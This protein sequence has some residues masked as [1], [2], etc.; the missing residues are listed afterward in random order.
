N[1]NLFLDRRAFLN[2]YDY[3]KDLNGKYLAAILDAVTP[4]CGGINLEY[5]FS[6]VDNHRLGAGT[7]LPHN[8]ISLIGVANGLEGD[9]RT[10]L[11][12]QMLDIHESLRLLI[13][14][15]HFPEVVLQVIQRKDATYEW[16]KNYWVH[17]VV[18]HPETR[19]LYRFRNHSW[20]DYEPTTE[21]LPITDDLE[22]ILANSTESLP[23]YLL[24]SS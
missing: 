7:K 22:E 15:E 21:K 12:A 4:V 13:V 18:V 11:P 24:K 14:V 16:F 20:E 8:V 19:K 10:G 3:S 5:Y 17:L 2:S 9:L 6:K 23:I 1:K